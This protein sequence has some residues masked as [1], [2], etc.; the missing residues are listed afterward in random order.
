MRL[1]TRFA[2]LSLAVLF[3]LGCAVV[4]HARDSEAPKRAGDR[5]LPCEPWV[6][7]HW[8]PFDSRALYAET[9]ISRKEW[10]DYIAPDDDSHSLGQLVEK[11]GK[12]PDAVVQK[13]MQRWNGRVSAPKLTELTRRANAL[14]TQGH[15]AQHVFFHYFH[16]P[17]LGIRAR[18]V[19]NVSPGDYHAARM[20]GFT[21]REIARHGG[22]PVSRAVR[23]ALVVL[24]EI[25][26]E[27]VASGQT[28]RAQA[29]QFLIEQRKWVPRWL[30]QS[31]RPRG[32]PFPKGSP[33]PAGKRDVQACQ[34]MVGAKHISGPRDPGAAPSGTSMYCN[35]PRERRRLSR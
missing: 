21:P 26:D 18:W 16:H 10:H 12:D 19:F 6:M 30:N 33:S 22:K 13:L 4:A 11:H 3:I 17:M 23:R 14:M 31:V 15:L 20:A 27:A 24:R 35:L 29:R 9:G 2:V 32:K 25:Q 28:T 5:W 8:L 7:Y 34:H 1:L